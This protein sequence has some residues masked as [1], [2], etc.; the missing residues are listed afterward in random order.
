MT[1]TSR[2]PVPSSLAPPCVRMPRARQPRVCSP[3]APT[4]L[5]YTL[6]RPLPLVSTSKHPSKHPERPSKDSTESPDSQT[7]P[8]LFPRIPR[9]GNSGRN[10]K[11]PFKPLPNRSTK[12]LVN[13]DYRPRSSLIPK[14]NNIR[15]QRPNHQSQG[16]TP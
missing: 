16:P 3:R 11:V 2:T 9:Q 4:R 1:V 12:E 14:P 10:K 8:Q 6:Q 13:T 15:F 5:P 7:L